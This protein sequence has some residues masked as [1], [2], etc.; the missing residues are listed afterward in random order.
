M[1]DLRDRI[2]A[3]YAEAGAHEARFAGADDAPDGLKDMLD[4]I[5]RRHFPP[6]RDAEVLD[7]GCGWGLLVHRA[8]LAGYSHAAGVDGSAQMV[9]VAERLAVAGIRQGDLFAALD[10]CADASLDAVCCLDVLEHLTHSEL[11][12]L[13][14]G[15]RRAL[16]PGGRWI[17]HTCNAESRFFGR[18]RYGDLT[19]QRG[20]TRGS[21][22]QLMTASGFG[23]V[24]CFEDAPPAR[25]MK[26]LL[27]RIAW[28]VLR[29][30]AL[31]WLVA[32]SGPTARH[33]ILSQN[34]LAVATR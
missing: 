5:V 17:I 15:V 22:E 7:L 11:L 2:Y 27:R 12:R 10:G 24:A 33:A 1:T 23:A 25:R 14:D 20:F 21:L 3:H 19:H 28:I 30:L 34:L 32:E 9:A 13:T 16:K 29:T 18:V 26:G 8:R 6:S 4:G 31:A